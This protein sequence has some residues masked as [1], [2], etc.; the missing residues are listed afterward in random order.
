MQKYRKSASELTENE[1]LDAVKFFNTKGNLNEPRSQPKTKVANPFSL[2]LLDPVLGKNILVQKAIYNKK[3]A[4]GKIDEVTDQERLLF[5]SKVDPKQPFL[6][7]I[8]DTK[9]YLQRDTETE[10]DAV[11][12][13]VSGAVTGLPLAVKAVGELLTT[14]IDYTFDTN[15]TKKLDDLTDEFLDYTGEPETFAGQIT[16]LGT[17]F[18]LPLGITSKIIGNIGKLKPFV[19]RTFGMRNA[20]LV[21]KNRFIQKGANL[22]QKSGTGALSLA[23]TDFVFSGRERIDPIFFERTDEEGKTGK[24][25]AAARFAN[26]VKFGKEGAL[27]GGLFPLIGSALGLGVRGIRSGSITICCKRF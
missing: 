11:G 9:T 12:D 19:G 26:K 27:V 16:Q 24:E 4:D 18:A 17:Q 8:F 20:N 10:I 25:L 2:L 1:V 3:I 14:G 13:V 22:A 23:A 5:E 15:Y 7:R 6:K 21:N